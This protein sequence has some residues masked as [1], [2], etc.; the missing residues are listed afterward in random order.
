MLTFLSFL[1]LSY[2]NLVGEIPNGRQLQT[3]TTDSFK[4]NPG[5]C[6]LELNKSCSGSDHNNSSPP[7]HEN[8]EEKREIEWK[9]VFAALGYVVGLGSI[10]W[11]LLICRTFREKYFDKIEDIVDDVLKAKNKRRDGARQVVRN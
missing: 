5:L 8:V 1:N 10:A 9:Y 7:E 2:N 3:F 4:G 11:L 6:V